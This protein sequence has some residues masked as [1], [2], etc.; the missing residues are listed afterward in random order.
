MRTAIVTGSSSGI[1]EALSLDLARWG[2]RVFG[3]DLTAT[4]SPMTS[5]D[6]A[7]FGGS[8]ESMI[9]DVTDRHAVEAAVAHVLEVT[10][11]TLDAVVANAGIREAGAFE[12][13]PAV[14]LKRLFDVNLGGAMH[15]T[16]AALPALRFTPDSR[17]VVVSSAGGL[18]ALPGLA[19]YCGSK[20]A[21][22]GWAESLAH[23]MVPLGVG[24]SVVEPASVQTGLWDAGTIHGDPDGPYASVVQALEDGDDRAW[25]RALDPH[26]VSATMVAV[27][28]G[29]RG[30]RHPIGLSARA[31]FLARGVVPAGVQRL[32]IGRLTR[33]DPPVRSPRRPDGV[34]MVTGCSSGFG[35]HTAVELARRGRRVAATM[36]DLSRRGPLDAALAEAG[37]ADRVEVLRLDVT[38]QASID[39]AMA[40]ADSWVRLAGDVGRLVG[41]VNNAGV[42]AVGPF[43]ELPPDSVDLVLDTNLHGTLAV[44]RAVLPRLRGHG[45]RIV[46]VTSSSGLGG[47]PTWSAY[48][49][50]KWGVEG[51]AE[52][53]AFEVGPHGIDVVLVEPGAFPT[54]I[55]R[56]DAWHGSPDGPY[57][58]LVEAMA[59]ADRRAAESGGDPRAVAR[60]VA[61]AFDARLSR[62][63][64]PVGRGAWLRW[65]ARGVV[66]FGV[67]RRAVAR[68]V[69]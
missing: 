58:P 36:R 37:V 63:R 6:L 54:G 46:C 13:T 53:L 55:W 69:G 2:W 8:V 23:E 30:F 31:R 18:S 3:F 28:E 34:I 16:R 39:E 19:A 50:S 56:D 21:L 15:L 44:T 9:V 45:G 64:R 66:P 65:A 57:G 40:V 62:T 41:L 68:M 26:S 59:A 12:E 29:R 33:Q 42:L 60:V 17:I 48:A 25:A 43:E 20:W 1:G 51:W 4:D 27:V 38:D 32:I 11:G 7:G 14:D 24:V 67:Q 35:L 22:E 61:R 49:A 47:L 52:S 5:S 10:G